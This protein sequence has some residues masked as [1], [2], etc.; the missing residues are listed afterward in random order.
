M[1]QHVKEAD[2][3]IISKYV[4]G[5]DRFYFF[6]SNNYWQARVIGTNPIQSFDVKVPSAGPYLAANADYTYAVVNDGSRTVVYI[7]GT[8][9]A[10]NS[11]TANVSNSKPLRFCNNDVIHTAN[12]FDGNLSQFYV[13]DTALTE[14][15]IVNHTQNVE[16]NNT[17]NP[18]TGGGTPT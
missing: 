9:L 1:N 12:Y 16:N 3:G 8:L 14:Q 18:F 5:T 2:H 10:N 7:N 15:Q 17:F 6:S 4:S 11:N 13:F